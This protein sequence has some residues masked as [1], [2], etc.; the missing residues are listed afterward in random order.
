MV[1]GW[2]MILFGRLH[3]GVFV[4]SLIVEQILNMGPG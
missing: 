3:I 2:W 4:D 1:I